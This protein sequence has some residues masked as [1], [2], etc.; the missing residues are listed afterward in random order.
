[1]VY[2]GGFADEKCI[3]LVGFIHVFF[4]D[5]FEINTLLLAACLN[6]SKASLFDGGF[7]SPGFTRTA[8]SYM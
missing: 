1:M 7:S 6:L 8:R 5:E 4:S 3:E 2:I